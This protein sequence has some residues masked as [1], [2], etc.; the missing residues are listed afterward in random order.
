MT[1]PSPAAV[2]TPRGIA[3]DQ[4]EKVELLVRFIKKTLV[5]I[6]DRHWPD[7]LCGTANALFTV[8]GHLEKLA[9]LAEAQG[10]AA[11]AQANADFANERAERI[12]E[13]LLSEQVDA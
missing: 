10:K 9:K 5:S 13:E 7:E 6:P 2:V 4:L 11:Q 3:F 12:R 8:T 1:D